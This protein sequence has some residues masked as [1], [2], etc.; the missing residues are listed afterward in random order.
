MI[1]VLV[2]DDHEL[3]RTGIRRILTDIAGVRV[4]GEA[5]S[6][7]EALA[8]ISACRPQVVLLDI[9]M[10]GVGG[11][12]TMR[13]LRKLH[14]HIKVIALSV[15]AGTTYPAR[16]LAAGAAGYLSKGCSAGEIA[17]AIR[18]VHA[19]NRY[20][21]SDIAHQ[22]ALAKHGGGTNSLVERLSERELQVLLMIARGQGIREVSDQLC[23]SPKTVSTYRYRLYDKLGVRNDV[24]LTHVAFR[25]GILSLEQAG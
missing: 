12:E 11:L 3:V 6:G 7:E 8:C 5:A 19:G 1:D 10:P 21:G 18:E 24:G 20:I 16:L 9:S 4:V 14:P 13:R 22:L 15:H 23:L 25:H 17:A 2:V